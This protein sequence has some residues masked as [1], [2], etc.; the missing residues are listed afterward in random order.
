MPLVNLRDM[1]N[2]AYDNNYAIGAFEL[3]SL[4]FIKGIIDAAERCRAPVILRVTE[5]HSDIFDFDIIMPVVEAAARRSSVPVAIQLHNDDSY[6][7]AVKGINHGCNGIT[8]GAPNKTFADNIEITLAIVEMAHSCGI[9]VEGGSDITSTATEAKFF[10][11]QTG[12]DFY[13][14]SIGTAHADTKAE[15]RIDFLRLKEIKEELAIPLVIDNDAALDEEHIRRLITNGVSKINYCSSLAG[16]AGMRIRENISSSDQRGYTGLTA[17]IKESISFEVERCIRLCD[18]AERADEV[19][20]SCAPWSSVEHVIIY[21][22]DGITDHQASS[23]MRQG[24]EI[25]SSIPGVRN[26]VTGRAVKSEAEYCYVWL[27]RFCHSDVINSY[28]N[29]PKHIDF[30][31][32]MFRPVAGE[33]ISID[34]QTP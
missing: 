32:N 7:A 30:A 33:R 3:V 4:D 16:I 26:V 23:M 34:Y 11:E 17:G 24:Q 31:D 25:L 19:L 9:P 13:T 5:A 10:V 14:V 27:I 29:H 2:H 20:V 12:V 8:V 6:D 21:N 28:R 15:A 1:L 18:S 22:T